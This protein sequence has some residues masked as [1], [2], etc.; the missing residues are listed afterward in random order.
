MLAV[1]VPSGGWETTYGWYIIYWGVPQGGI[2]RPVSHN[3]W[4]YQNI[5]KYLLSTITYF[6][7]Y[8]F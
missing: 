7:E 3:V 6:L 8:F 2:L 5:I 1:A 4:V